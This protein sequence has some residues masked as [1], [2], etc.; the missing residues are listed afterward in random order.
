MPSIT[1]VGS[2]DAVDV[3][4]PDTG[5]TYTVEQGKSVDVPD[6]LAKG[7]LEQADNWQKAEQKRDDKSAPKATKESN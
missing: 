4:D 5:R 7:L 6:E 3:P 2:H 1:Y